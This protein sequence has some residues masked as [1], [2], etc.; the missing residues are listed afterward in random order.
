MMLCVK[1]KYFRLLEVPNRKYLFL[2]YCL[3]SGMREK[4]TKDVSEC[5]YFEED[6]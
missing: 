2:P 3:A 4:I 5:E 6:E 1:C